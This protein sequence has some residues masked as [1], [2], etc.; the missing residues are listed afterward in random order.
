MNIKSSYKYQLLDY[1]KGVAIFYIVILWVYAMLSITMIKVSNGNESSFGGMDMATAIFLFVCGLCSFKENFLMLSQ[2][3]VSRKTIF[4]GRIMVTVTIALAMALIDNVIFW[5]FKAISSSLTS[6]IECQSA[7]VQIYTERMHG[8]SSLQLYA[9]NLLFDIAIYLGASFIGY[10]I[11]LMFYRMNK[12]GRVIAGVGVPVF[13]SVVLPAI[14]EF[15][16]NG[17]ISMLIMRVGELMMG[18]PQGVIISFIG[19]AI[20]FGALSWLLMRRAPVRQ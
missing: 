10:F 20:V 11:T 18:T 2:N 13:L 14:D 3:G 19:F 6:N 8:I 17:R 7:F 4:K 16:T 1:K 9:G 5:V 15:L 12:T